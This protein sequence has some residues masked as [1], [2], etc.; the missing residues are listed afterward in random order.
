MI[1]RKKA[2]TQNKLNDIDLRIILLELENIIFNSLEELIDTNIKTENKLLV[3]NSINR[4]Y[5]FLNHIK[6]G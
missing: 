6:K 4:I 2:M 1:Q 5:R 3:K